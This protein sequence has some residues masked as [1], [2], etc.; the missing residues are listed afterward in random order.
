MRSLASLGFHSREG[1]ALPLREQ[2]SVKSSKNMKNFKAR[3]RLSLY[4]KSSSA[5]LISRTETFFPLAS[6]TFIS[7]RC[8]HSNSEKVGQ[9]QLLPDAL[10]TWCAGLPRCP[11][12]PSSPICLQGL[13]AKCQQALMHTQCTMGGE[14]PVEVTAKGSSF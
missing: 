4:Y 10:L 11:S 6:S 8:F 1:L 14:Q 3:H 13:T 2:V 9:R 12:Q 7:L 5:H